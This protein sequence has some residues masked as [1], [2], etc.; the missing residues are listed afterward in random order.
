MLHRTVLLDG[1]PDSF[2]GVCHPAWRLFHTAPSQ[3]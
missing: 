3:Q 1:E 2:H